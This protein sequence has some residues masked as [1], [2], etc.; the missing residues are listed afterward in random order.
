MQHNTINI[1]LILSISFIIVTYCYLTSSKCFFVTLVKENRDIT[2]EELEK[3][4]DI[5]NLLKRENFT[6]DIFLQKLE[7][8]Q[9]EDE[10]RDLYQ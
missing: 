4:D 3:L 2:N 7:S 8:L 5:A 1:L 10:I 9:I 6:K